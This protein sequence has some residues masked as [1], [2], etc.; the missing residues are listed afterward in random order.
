METKL[1]TF[2]KKYIFCTAALSQTHTHTYT[3]N[4][5]KIRPGIFGSNYSKKNCRFFFGFYVFGKNTMKSQMK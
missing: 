4:V 5:R 2:Q 1:K 3:H